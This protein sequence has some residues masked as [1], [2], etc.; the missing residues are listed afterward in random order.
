M[1]DHTPSRTMYAY[2]GCRCTGC[3]DANRAYQADY[4]DRQ[5]ALGYVY[6]KGY[7]RRPRRAA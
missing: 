7:L 3:K 2:H 6:I 1:T 5:R 4:R